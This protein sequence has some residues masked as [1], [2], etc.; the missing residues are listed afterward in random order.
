VEQEHAKY[1]APIRFIA[2]NDARGVCWQPISAL[3]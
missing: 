1:R 3:L 2:E